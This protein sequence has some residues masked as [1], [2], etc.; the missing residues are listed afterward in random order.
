[1]D[2]R[3][4]G[5]R[6]GALAVALSSAI[7]GCRFTDQ[8]RVVDPQQLTSALQAENARLKDQNADLLAKNERLI[9]RAGDDAKRLRE[10]LDDKQ[11]F[12]AAVRGYQNER[13][14]LAD[15]FERFKTEAVATSAPVPTAMLDELE[16]FAQAHPMFRFDRETAT[17]SAAME[18]VF[19]A[20]SAEA[21]APQ[22]EQALKSL[23]GILRSSDPGT[24]LSV[25]IVA[26]QTDDGV[27]KTSADASGTDPGAD[28]AQARARRVR[29]SLRAASGLAEERLGAVGFV[30]REDDAAQSSASARQIIIRVR[31]R[32]VG[33]EAD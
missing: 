28:L 10:A 23:G 22:A 17:L 15:A 24:A 14:R 27:R 25:L 13:E 16:S 12:E 4:R 32:R 19:G 33:G 18:T 2:R 30:A 20:K 9:E 26:R 11:R 7:A 6:L 21:Y 29:E 8:T 31:Y 1:M 3:W 5:T